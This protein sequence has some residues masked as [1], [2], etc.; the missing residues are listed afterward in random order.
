MKLGNVFNK[1]FGIAY[2]KNLAT[3][4]ERRAFIIE[5]CNSIELEYKIVPAINGR[6]LHDSSFT[7]QHGPF[8]LTY[9][10]S[11]GFIGNQ[12]TS[13]QILNEAIEQ[14]LDNFIM[15]D[16]DC[17]FNHAVN[18]SEKSLIELEENLPSDWDVIILGDIG[19]KI[20]TSE[21]IL[22]HKCSAHRE[23]A[24][25]HG[26]AISKRVFTE[27]QELLAGRQ[28]LGDGVIG[29]LIDIGKNVYKIYPSLCIQDRSLFSDI[30][31]LHHTR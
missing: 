9:P 7:I 2:I 25:S 16:D 11:A 10:A 8:I 15:L 20:V 27:M 13:C 4:V 29:R 22:Y 6:D 12:I 5:Q 21:S 3:S 23:A 17:V 18:I 26:I 14:N 31:Q 30:N 28:W 24:G 1:L 19:G